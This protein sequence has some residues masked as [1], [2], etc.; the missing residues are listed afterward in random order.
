[1]GLAFGNDDDL[2]EEYSGYGLRFES[3]KVVTE[4]LGIRLEFARFRQSWR[5]ITLSA[6][7]A[8][9]RIPE[10]YRTRVTVEPAV[11]FAF[12]SHLRVMGGVSISE[13]ESQARS[14]ESQ[15]ASAAIGGIYYSHSSLEA[16]YELR[17]AT[18]A[19]ESDLEYKRHFAHARY[20]YKQGKSEISARF[21]VG[22]ITG[23]APLFERFSLGDSSTLRGWN[24]FDVAPAGGRRMF[25]HSL[26]YRY[27]GFALFV[28]GGS[29]WDEGTDQR[30]RFSTGFGF[31]KD[32]VFLTLGV[33]LN[34][35]DAGVAFM[36][37]VRF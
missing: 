11:T 7:D 9:P 14:P 16:S 30:I 32:G 37:G 12:N 22:G 20:E 5:E 21:A 8:D 26:E 24:R 28:D 6:L 17:S 2:I 29:V 31:H 13:L 36:M 1:M 18:R 33:P 23:Q 19:L 10:A 3:R 25:H 15:M 35:D 4:R 34:A 27:H